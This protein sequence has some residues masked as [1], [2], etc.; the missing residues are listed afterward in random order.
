MTT[1]PIAACDCRFLR[2][3]SVHL[4]L[5]AV[6]AAFAGTAVV[7]MVVLWPGP[8]PESP[9]AEPLF[10]G[11][12]RSATEIPCPADPL[13]P[14]DPPCLRVEIEVMEGD[15]AGTI[16]ELDTGEQGFPPFSVGDRVRVARAAT[17]NGDAPMYYV[18]DFARLAPLTWLF[19]VF[20]A[21]VLAVGRW[22][23][24]RSLAGV[25]LSLLVIVRFVIPAILDGRNPM[26]VA[27]VGGL[28]VIFLTLYFTHGFDLKTTTALVGIAAALVLTAVLGLVFSSVTRLTGLATE[29]A[30]LLQF[31]A[32]AVSLRGLVL[33]GLVIGALGVLDDVTVSQASTVLAVH[34]AD[35]RQSWVTLYRR[36]MRV[37]RDHIASTVNTLVF[38]YTGASI[39]LLILFSTGGVP[40]T[41]VVNSELVAQ[42]IVKTFVGSIGLVCAVPLTTV[43]AVTV[44]AGR[45]ASG[46]DRSESRRHRRSDPEYED[47]LRDLRE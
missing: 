36:A 47:W 43:L 21:V 2:G 24:L 25:G 3:N 23:G 1:T 45:P 32:E 20:V 22:H 16:F 26:A 13:L 27:L 14:V 39:P 40:F 29:E 44:V 7:G 17:A 5:L 6:V 35:P 42:E 46:A 37:G 41:E 4:W 15:G 12:V 30:Q 34:E 9:D 28:V 8:S 19:A 18:Q 38:A 31:S 33:A 10:D 11:I